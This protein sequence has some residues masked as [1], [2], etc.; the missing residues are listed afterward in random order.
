[1]NIFVTGASGF[2]GSHLVD[3]LLKDGHEVFGLS[4][5]SGS[6]I[7][8]LTDFSFLNDFFNHT[9]IDVMFHLAACISGEDNELVDSNV[10]GTLNLLECAHRHNVKNLVYSSSMEVYG[11]PCYLPV[12]EKHPTR[13]SNFYGMTKL[14]G[15]SICEN[16]SNYVHCIVLR[17]SGVFGPGK[18]KGAIS[19]FIDR[20]L[21]GEQPNVDGGEQTTDFVY[22]SDVV[23]ANTKALLN[24]EKVKFDAFNIGSGKETKLL[25]IATF[26][27]NQTNPIIVPKIIEENA[28]RNFRFYYSI[29]KAREKLKYDP[30]PLENRIREFIA[31][32]K[33]NIHD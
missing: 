10:K 27:I 23:D 17:Y 9:K 1:M 5:K 28:S 32:K 30:Q 7:G 8:D 3:A 21:A 4:R 2:I 31:Y 6:V 20:T 18:S 12:D 13:P 11:R 22:V 29:E 24:I 15:E 25:D 33:A 14:I 16:Y 19:S 26:I